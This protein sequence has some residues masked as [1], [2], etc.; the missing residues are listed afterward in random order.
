[1]RVRWTPDAA[2]DLERIC[3]HIAETSPETARRVARQIVEGVA[4]LHSFPNRGRL[5]R[6]E[7]TRGSCSCLFPLSRSTRYTTNYTFCESCT[8]LSDGRS[9]AL[10]FARRG[11]RVNP[12]AAPRVGQCAPHSALVDTTR[13]P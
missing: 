13:R 6:V 11:C 7:G 8:V 4:S 12:L 9:R 3:D 5:G 1:M 10:I 2:N